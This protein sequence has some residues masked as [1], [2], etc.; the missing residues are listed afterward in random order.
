[1]PITIYEDNQ[2]AIKIANNLV[3]HLHIKHIDVHYHAICGHI[4]S[5]EVDLKY[6]SMDWM[7]ADGLMKATNLVTQK[8]VSWWTKASL[9][10]CNRARVVCH[11]SRVRVQGQ[12]LT[13]KSWTCESNS[14]WLTSPELRL[15]LSSW[16][17]ESSLT[18]KLTQFVCH[19]RLVSQPSSPHNLCILVF[20][21]KDLLNTM[22]PSCLTPSWSTSHSVVYYPSQLH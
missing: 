15:K 9:I 14:T 17:C 6:L 4:E 8:A 19:T 2:S 21:M 10:S 13:H 1:M 12:D 7:I 5:G 3:N 11:T 22:W 16:T 20:V 18:H